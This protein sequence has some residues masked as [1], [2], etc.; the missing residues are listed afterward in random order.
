MTETGRRYIDLSHEIV[1]GMTTHPGIPAPAISTFLSYEDSAA[2]YAPG[3]T[4]QIGR[5]DLVANTGTYIDTPAHRFAGRGDTADLALDTIADLPGVVVDCRSV[6]DR[7]IGPDAFEGIALAGL[8]V[9]IRTDW[10]RHWGTPEYLVGHPF[11]TGAAAERLVAAGAAAVGI[12]SLNV[13]SL[14]DASRP[15]HTA[16]LG[17]G[18]P[19]LEHLTG[20]G[21][22]PTGRF[23]FFA[24][25]PRVR[26]MATFPVRAFAIVGAG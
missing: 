19:L 21:G 6:K 17:A 14:E 15:A 4:F 20:L 23:R 26:G 9:L 12:D 25:P 3:T 7:A 11:L 18:L 24:V 5:I 1:D 10:D 22:L 2:R 13:D 16:I 8:A